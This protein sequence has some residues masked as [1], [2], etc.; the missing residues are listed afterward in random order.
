MRRS[1][2][3][4]LLRGAAS[5]EGFEE[6]IALIE[7]LNIYSSDMAVSLTSCGRSAIIG[8]PIAAWTL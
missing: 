7:S 3:A 6:F 8:E 1:K 4:T 2:P 5:T